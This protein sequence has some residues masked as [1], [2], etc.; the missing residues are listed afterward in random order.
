MLS[1]VSI[2]IPGL[3]LA[4]FWL[5]VWV[6]GSGIG[7]KRVLLSLSVLYLLSA[8]SYADW[9]AIEQYRNLFQEREATVR[10]VVVATSAWEG[11]GYVDLIPKRVNPLNLQARV[12][13]FYRGSRVYQVGE[14]VQATGRVGIASKKP[15]QH[16]L[17]WSPFSLKEYTLS[18][19]EEGIIQF[20][21]KRSL[22]LRGFFLERLR[23][24]A[25]LGPRARGLLAAL[26]FGERGEL[27][28]EFWDL[29]KESG[30]LH[31]FAISGFHLGLYLSLFAFFPKGKSAWARTLCLLLFVLLSGGPASAVRAAAAGLYALCGGFRGRRTADK[32]GLM[33][34]GLILLWI[35]PA[36]LW[37]LGFR[38]SFLAVW[39][40]KVY[41]GLAGERPKLI[42][43][44]GANL[45]V[46]ACLF[47]VLA[48]YF[49]CISLWAPFISLVVFPVVAV[50]LGLGLLSL[51]FLAAGLG[52]LYFGASGWFLTPLAHFL[53]KTL[54]AVAGLPGAQLNLGTMGLTLPVAA[55]LAIY[56]LVDSFRCWLGSSG[57]HLLGVGGIYGLVLVLL[58]GASIS[59]QLGT[60]TS[61]WLR[62]TALA[63]G[64][65][66]SFH[67]RLPGG[68]DLLVDG[69]GGREVDPADWTGRQVVLAYLAAEGITR[70]DSVLVSH[71]H[72][73][74]YAGLLPVVAKI[75]KASLVTPGG[76]ALPFQ[77]G[78]GGKRAYR[79]RRGV[80]FRY[81]GVRGE[82]LFPVHLNQK[83]LTEA[84][85]SSVV[86]LVNYH[87]FSMLFTGD[88][89]PLK[90]RDLAYEGL[91]NAVTV[92]KV[93]HHGGRSTT[94]ELLEATK[95]ALAV[96]PGSPRRET[97]AL[98]QE[99]GIE[100][101][102]TTKDGNLRITTDGSR[103]HVATTEPGSGAVGLTP[104]T[105]VLTLIQVL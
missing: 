46:T 72:T 69:G 14:R 81:R 102:A 99:S 38:L 98:L 54:V 29:V 65:G 62:V 42:S 90:Q 21:Q 24:V 89:P 101:L 32:A 83:L 26:I 59:A 67:L 6:M 60:A 34:V 37:D 28:V 8:V 1:N 86:L 103:W 40:L 56:K 61:P 47:P 85:S 16:L 3:V 23:E 31:L 53:Q 45:F 52:E 95:P 73:D 87:G 25:N 5:V 50:F 97:A 44:L 91:L 55:L 70:L 63:V 88:L 82:V 58:T 39:S 71:W 105:L 68:A 18:T 15:P 36:Y 76:L 74:H 43:F 104:E 77:F 48:C 100:A 33:R 9:V 80:G 22:D 2:L 49:G 4:L 92:L 79:A 12:R 41:T 10:G 11:G 75:P 19:G 57:K 94:R 30:I 93:P 13:A 84:N 51:P 66:D 35:N 96:I 20:G 78:S 27:P 7:F 64:Q 17:W